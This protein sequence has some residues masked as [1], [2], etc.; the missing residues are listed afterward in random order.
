M[1]TISSNQLLK[2]S[3]KIIKPIEIEFPIKTTNDISNT[4]E[5]LIKL[6]TDGI[7]LLGN[8]IAILCIL[9]FIISVINGFA[10]KSHMGTSIMEDTSFNS[11]MDWNKKNTPIT[12]RRNENMDWTFK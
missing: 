4:M 3:P 1:N 5:L 12:P 6:L 7:L 9:K 11:R 8:G 2:S 10:T